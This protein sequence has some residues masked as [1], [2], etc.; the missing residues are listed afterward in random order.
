[1]NLVMEPA[2]IG[3]IKLV[4]FLVKF[5]LLMP[6]SKGF[7]IFTFTCPHVIPNLY[8]TDKIFC[9]PL[10]KNVILI[11][12]KKTLT[13]GNRCEHYLYYIILYKVANQ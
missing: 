2:V 13:F 10:N 6:S 8:Y 1:M 9:L 4:N 12:I 5:I 7:K 11:K 3:A